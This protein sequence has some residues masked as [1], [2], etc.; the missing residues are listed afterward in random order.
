MSI[1]RAEHE[2]LR[3]E[4]TITNNDAN[5][6]VADRK[7][8]VMLLLND[9]THDTRVMK[10]ATSLSNHGF[11]VHIVALM[12]PGLESVQDVNGITI[13]RITKR[14]FT[15]KLIPILGLLLPG[16]SR[17]PKIKCQNLSAQQSK[18]A[19]CAFAII[20]A[21]LRCM[22]IMVPVLFCLILIPAWLMAKA[23][24]VLSAIFA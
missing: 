2:V 14:L 23:M 4:P 9:C 20:S 22:T 10:E 13:H 6:S 19:Q 7:R 18:V 15:F 5:S 1:V 12:N 11:E 3:A 17:I 16:I 24:T 8:L 21:V